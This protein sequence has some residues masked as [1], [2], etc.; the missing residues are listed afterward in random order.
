ML[1]EVGITVGCSLSG[2]LPSAI[3]AEWLRGIYLPRSSLAALGINLLP[4]TSERLCSCAVFGLSAVALDIYVNHRYYFCLWSWQ[5]S[6]WAFS[7]VSCL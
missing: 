5:L 2:H 7:F 6:S 1:G 3:A 4:F